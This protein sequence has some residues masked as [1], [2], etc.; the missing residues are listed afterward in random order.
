MD[1][2]LALL[3]EINSV[4]NN[5]KGFIADIRL[6]LNLFDGANIMKTRKGETVQVI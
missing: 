5:P 1:K 4:R 6:Q 2:G 3:E